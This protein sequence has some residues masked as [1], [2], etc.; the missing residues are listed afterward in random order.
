MRR[1]GTFSTY[2]EIDLDEVM[3]DMKTRDLIQELRDRAASGD[4]S[5]AGALAIPVGE[6]ER[7]M[8]ETRL[9]EIERAASEDHDHFLILM[10]R[11]RVRLLP[12]AA[13]KGLAQ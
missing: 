1:R 2:V 3:A 13:Q 7:E 12:E 9:A 4:A 5:A 6:S 8:L 11:L 10:N